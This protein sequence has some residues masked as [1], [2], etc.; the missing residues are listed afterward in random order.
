MKDEFD[1]EVW[2]TSRLPTAHCPLPTAHYP[3]PTAHCPLLTAQSF[4]Y[5]EW[6]FW[7][8]VATLDMAASKPE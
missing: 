3:L 1:R 6:Q 5:L 2:G 8:V 7:Q 4:L